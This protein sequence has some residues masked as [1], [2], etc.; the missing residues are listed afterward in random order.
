MRQL[1]AL[2][3][4]PSAHARRALTLTALAL[5]LGVAFGRPAVVVLAAPP[6]TYLALA[7]RRRPP[8]ALSVEV[9]TSA[10]RCFEREPV[11]VAVRAGLP[12]R[13]DVVGLRLRPTGQAQL[14]AG[15]DESAVVVA[16]SAAEVGIT[17]RFEV[18]RWGR[19][20]LGY[21]TADLFS[22]GRLLHARAEVDLGDLAV[23]PRPAPLPRLALPAGRRGL[24]GDHLARIVGAGTEFAGIRPLVAS[25]DAARINW[26]ASSRFQRLYITETAAEHAVD[27][28]LVLDAFHDI[29][30]AERSSLDLT[31]RGATGA[32]RL[33]LRNHDRVG[34]VVI[35]GWLRWLRADV[36]ERQFY[37]IADAVLD[38]I[39]DQSYVDPDVARLPPAAVPTGGDI[40]V[41]SPLLDERVLHAIEAVRARGC[42]VT[43]V[44]VLTARPAAR[45]PV[46]RV[47]LRL[48]WL[49]R[50][51]TRAEL[52]DIGVPV[53]SWDGRVPLDAVLEPA[54]SHRAAGPP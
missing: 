46:E 52:A 36:G 23:L 49:D 25:D 40:V 15:G 41:F 31:V 33:L 34:L 14:V 16:A 1:R 30:P 53:V 44:D 13:V 24:A 19:R 27:V 42:R 18:L 22:A 2:D 48:W 21:V 29:G 3:W 6:L 11:D 7:E 38:V 45:L 32:A 50:T 37:R 28:V 4:R 35:G 39:G 10:R 9:S 47:A 5:V 54:L 51:A 20:P 26:R 12:E 8:A 17:A 43:V